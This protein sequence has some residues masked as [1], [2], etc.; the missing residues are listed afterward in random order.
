MKRSLGNGI[1]FLEIGLRVKGV[2]VVDVLVMVK[3]W[4]LYFLSVFYGEV[5]LGCFLVGFYFGVEAVVMIVRVCSELDFFCY[6]CSFFVE[7]V[8]SWGRVF[9]GIII[10][11]FCGR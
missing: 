7:G 3:K 9:L 2:Y 10:R 6:W 11:S 5:E 1:Y 4:L 8:V